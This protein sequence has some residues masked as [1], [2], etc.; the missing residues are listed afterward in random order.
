MGIGVVVVCVLYWK[1]VLG[2]LVGVFLLWIFVKSVSNSQEDSYYEEDEGSRSLHI[3]HHRDPN[4]STGSRS[5]S[6]LRNSSLY[7]PR[8]NQKGVDFITGRRRRR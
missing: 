8:V 5:S 3:F 4:R 2:L 6:R 1:I 7:I